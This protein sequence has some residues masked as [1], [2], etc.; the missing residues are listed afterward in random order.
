M[1]NIA[2]VYDEPPGSVAQGHHH[3]TGGTIHTLVN[4]RRLLLWAGALGGWNGSL[5]R[6]G[7]CLRGGFPSV[8]ATH[9]GNHKT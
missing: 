6:G 8:V 4:V 3:R 5:V 7:Y 2:E 1:N 9:G